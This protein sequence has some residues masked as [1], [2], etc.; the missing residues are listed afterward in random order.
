[1]LLGTEAMTQSGK[2][3]INNYNLM[4]ELSLNGSI[5]SAVQDTSGTMFFG[6]DDGVVAY[7]GNFWMNV[8]RN[9]GTIRSL[10]KSKSNQVFYG[11]LND[12]GRI[13][14][15]VINGYHLTSLSDS[16]PDSLK[17]FGEIWSIA[18]CG[19]RIFFQSSGTIFVEDSSTL[20]AFPVTNSYH[21]AFA[22]NGRYYANQ[23]GTGLTVFTVN[24]FDPVPGGQIFG[25]KIISIALPYHNGNLLV[26]TRTNGIYLFNPDSGTVSS[27]F[28]GV[29]QTESYLKSNNLYHAI[30]LPGGNLAFST[31]YGGTLITD[32]KGNIQNMLN[33]RHGLQDNVHY[34]LYFTSDLNLWMCTSNGISTWDI[35]SPFIYW[36]YTSGIDGIVLDIRKYQDRIFIGSLTGLYAIN[37]DFNTV[38]GRKLQVERLLE[39]E[40]WNLLPVAFGGDKILLLGTGRGLYMM[41]NK[42]IRQVRPGGIVL[43][44]LQVK[45]HPNFI[46]SF[47]DDAVEV[48][49]WKNHQL[50]YRHTVRGA[51]T[52]LRTVAEDDQGNIWIGTRKPDIVKIPAGQFLTSSGKL[53]D[54]AVSRYTF[55][56]PLTDVIPWEGS[57]LFTNAGGLF[58]Y[59]D[60]KDEF[61]RCFLF[62]PEIAA[63]QQMFSCLKKD[64][65]NNVWVGGNE[66]FLY[67]ADGTYSIEKLH[68]HQIEDV[69]SAFVFLHENEHRTWIGGNNGVYL[70]R[71]NPQLSYPTNT[72]TLINKINL[73]SD[74]IAYYI[75][76]SSWPAQD[77][78]SKEVLPDYPLRID[79]NRKNSQITFQYALPYFNSENK[80]QY[81]YRLLNYSDTWTKW[82]NEHTATFSNLNPGDYT[83]EVRALT[84]HKQTSEP[85]TISIHVPTPW[86]LTHLTLILFVLVGMGLVYTTS[87]I[88]SRQ[89]VRKHLRI[90]DVIQKRLQE[91]RIIDI[92]QSVRQQPENSKAARQQELKPEP[93][94]SP[95]EKPK[96]SQQQFL[97]KA[98]EIV[99]NH[100][101]DP[102]LDVK[103]FCNKL[104]MNQAF[105]YRKMISITGMSI[106]SFIR[107]T[108]LK[109]AA[110]MLLETDLSISEVA[111]QTGFS[112]PSY[113][114]RCFKNEFGKSPRD[115][116]QGRKK[117]L[118]S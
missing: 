41:E 55:A 24:G 51:F 38:S 108:R 27:P 33:R 112:A 78:S 74:S 61:A 102:D 14:H 21:R 49:E 30:E 32:Q 107:N 47:K 101:S 116:I 39:T 10:M 85:A 70:F 79:L 86:Y 19:N 3:I 18:E 34:Y 58:A 54:D 35:N 114:T 84:I 96:N 98:L 29:P 28:S 69:F 111:Y 56:Q 93:E 43:K 75:N 62:G 94:N 68:F 83:F 60:Q 53:P 40:V 4:D 16:L 109:K 110:Q 73:T 48:F 81:S 97:E 67:H 31:L 88:I 42:S 105:A 6:C 63:T 37:S 71:N 2:Y 80:T 100:M 118:N 103:A 50:V 9:R 82:S 25:D 7:D 87:L 23:E 66:I 15:D 104:D 59:N 57:V 22:A 44:I 77:K 99:E 72:R 65:R 5:W 20:Q 95:S 8:S 52:G 36:D 46:L 12:F 91:K 11:S 45:E 90:E 76:A 115:F 106:N 117:I 89:R 113:F 1:M 17:N 26:C 92:V 13:D 64:F